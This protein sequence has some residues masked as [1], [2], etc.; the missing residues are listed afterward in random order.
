MK[1][2]LAQ[3]PASRSSHWENVY[4]RKQSQELSWFSPHLQ[5]SLALIAHANLPNDRSMIDVGAGD[6]TLVDDLLGLG[7]SRITLLDISSQALERAKARLQDRSVSLTWIVGDIT[8]V[9][10]NRTFD[11]WHDR[12]VFHF[13]TD[14][15]ERSR[16]AL[17]LKHALNPSGFAV[18]A[19]FSLEGPEKCSGLPT[20]RYSA[21]TLL[22]ELGPSFRLVKTLNDPH[23]TPAGKA[24]NFT[25]CLFQKSE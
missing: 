13:L 19:T 11:L 22:K 5:H 8:K 16:Y 15:R 23:I 24:Q 7:Y 25:Y 21:E 6:S 12:A 17:A 2:P 20:M 1:S 3:D 9:Q 4:G 18:M 14:P 10:L